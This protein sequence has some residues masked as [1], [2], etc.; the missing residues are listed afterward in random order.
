MG[1]DG[2]CPLCVGS[3]EGRD[4]ERRGVGVQP[5]A[6][7]ARPGRHSQ[8]EPRRGVGDC[9]WVRSRL[10]SDLPVIHA[11][12]TRQGPGWHLPRP[13]VADHVSWSRE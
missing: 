3:S 12:R 13:L 11:G 9:L 6:L 1:L 7:R 10:Q 5:P 2:E 4:G 8:L